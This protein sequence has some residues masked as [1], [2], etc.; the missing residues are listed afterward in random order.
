GTKT[1]ILLIMGPS[2]SGKTTLLTMAGGLLRPTSGLI[3]VAGAEISQLSDR[4]L[5]ALRRDKVGFVFQ[6]FNLLTALTALENV[7]IVL[8]L[9]GKSGAAARDKA[10]SLL[11]QFGLSQRLHYRPQQLSGGEMQRVSIARALANEPLL[12]LADEPTA[13]LDSQRGREV[14]ELLRRV[15]KEESKTLVIVSHD[16]RIKDIADSVVW[17]EDGK[18]KHLSQ[19]LKQEIPVWG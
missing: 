19:V 13:N 2:G 18:L 1:K 15:A 10:R 12:V 17:L 7:E 11:N 6:C 8:N 9:A 3:E 16:Q 4:Q 5:S 14:M